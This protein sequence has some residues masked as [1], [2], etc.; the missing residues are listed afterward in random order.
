MY[1]KKQK[2]TGVASLG[3]GKR[4]RI[5]SF[6]IY[7][8][9][10]IYIKRK[11]EIRLPRKAAGGGLEPA[12]HI[13]ISIKIKLHLFWLD[14]KYIGAERGDTWFWICKYMC[15]W[16]VRKHPGGN[17]LLFIRINNI[18]YICASFWILV[19]GLGSIISPVSQTAND[20]N[21]WPGLFSMSTHS[22]SIPFHSIPF[23]SHSIQFHSIPFNSIPIPFNS[24]QF[25]SHSIQFHSIPFHSIQFNSIP[26]PFN[27][28]PFHS[29]FLLFTTIFLF[30]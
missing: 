11:N 5:F 19:P 12:P 16:G 13:F 3:G 7:I 20:W 6:Y 8:Y 15:L 21:E 1:I 23:H 9:I 26:I 4:G 17:G 14:L 2:K 27:S 25:N 22:H 10:Y 29:L 30:F 24:I 28:I 18:Y